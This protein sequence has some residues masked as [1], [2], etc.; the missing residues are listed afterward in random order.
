M[1]IILVKICYVIIHSKVQTMPKQQPK[2]IR[3]T[4]ALIALG[5]LGSAL[6]LLAADKVVNL[7]TARHYASDDALYQKFTQKTGI[8]VNVVSAGD[9]PLLERIRSEGAAS[10]ADVILLADAARLWKAEQ[11]GLFAPIQS[12]ALSKAI[13]ADKRSGNMWVGL[14]S[15]ARVIVIDPN[16]VKDTDIRTYEDLAKPS[17]RGMVCTRSASHPYMLSLIGAHLATNGAEKTEAWMRGIVNNLARPSKGGDTDQIRAVASGEC[18][19]AVTNSYYYA[20]LMRSEKPADKEVVARTKVI[21]PNQASA[22]S[23]MNISG[24]GIAKNAPNA[25]NAVAFLEFLASKEIQAEFADGNNEWPVVPGVVYK[26]PALESLGKFKADPMPV[27]KYAEQQR[28]AQQ[29][30]DK[31]NWK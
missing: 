10:P 29:L 22:G 24:G 18:A 19:I 12:T 23:H 26:N 14:T 20:R 21:W 4:T 6:P 5:L 17:F 15:R 1:R 11:D 3:L 9:E 7:Y 25:K 30:V 31:I 13:P 27:A 2:P 16:K 28:T 8:K